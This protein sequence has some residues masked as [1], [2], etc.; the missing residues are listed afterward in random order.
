MSVHNIRTER[1]RLAGDV[2][3]GRARASAVP[4][5]VDDYDGY[6]GNPYSIGRHGPREQVIE[7][8]ETY[9]RGRIERDR[10]YRDRVRELH[11]KRLFCW[12][13]PLACHGDVLERLAG[14]LNEAA[15]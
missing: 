15:A 2:Y 13:K 9:A 8:F 1:I 7:K 3:I 12:C 5:G 6:F 14:E 4:H 10:L 11:G